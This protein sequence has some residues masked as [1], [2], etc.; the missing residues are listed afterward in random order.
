[1]NRRSFLTT[2]FGSAVAATMLP[3]IEQ[4][5][6]AL[7]GAGFSVEKDRLAWRLAYEA[8]HLRAYELF[9]ADMLDAGIDILAHHLERIGGLG[10]YRSDGIRISTQ[11]SVMVSSL[12]QVGALIPAMS[13]LSEA[14]AS[15]GIDRFVIPI[16][17]PG[18]EFADTI[19][20]LRMA[21][22]YQIDA[23]ATLYRFDVVG[24]SSPAG[25]RIANKRRADYT[26]YLIR[27]R[28][29]KYPSPQRLV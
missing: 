14:L 8:A 3:A 12:D 9:K 17:P 6:E 10:C 2:L 24:G 15:R 19:G 20:P 4:E 7:K 18:C 22:Q 28:L 16:L 26:K 23:G 21:V 11:R 29:G 13:A 5:A 27:S 25:E 1:M